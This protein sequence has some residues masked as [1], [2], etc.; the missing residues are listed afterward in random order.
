MQVN[1]KTNAGG[2]SSDPADSTQPTQGHPTVAPS[3]NG[4][5][6]TGHE[7]TYTVDIEGTLHEWPNATITVAEICA[8]GGWDAST[9]VIEIDKDNNERQL[10]GDDVVE[11]KPGVG[12]AKKVRW[13]RGDSLFD[14]RLDEELQLLTN[15]FLGASRDGTWYLLPGFLVPAVGWNRVAT[16]VALRVQPGYPATPPYAFFV[17]AGLRVNDALPDNYQEPVGEPIPFGGSWGMFSWQ[18]DDGEWRAAAT[19]KDGSNLLNFA[20]GVAARFRQGK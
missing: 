5:E 1:T 19:A 8:L 13:K 11:L 18:A 4:P 3:E 17:P 10:A 7:K 15:R 9:G 20:L 16:D 12:F 2:K 14:A 6:A